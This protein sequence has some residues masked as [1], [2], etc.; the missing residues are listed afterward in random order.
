MTLAT[1]YYYAW[2]RVTPERHMKIGFIYAGFS[3]ITLV[4]ISGILSVMLSPGDWAKT[5]QILDAYRN[6]IMAGR[7]PIGFRVPRDLARRHQPRRS[8]CVPA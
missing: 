6:L 2:D 5:H 8:L 1:F 7:H 3:W 4:V